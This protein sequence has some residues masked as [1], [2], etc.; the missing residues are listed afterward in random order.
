MAFVV[1]ESCIRCKFMDCVPVCPADCFHAG[2]AMLVIDPQ[3]CIECG[4][5]APECPV[6]AIRPDTDE[7]MGGWALMNSKYAPA[8]PVITAKAVTPTDAMQWVGASGKLQAVF[9]V[10]DP[11]Q[12]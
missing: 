6:H 4:I 8:W 11:A 5:C 2:E 7:G 12:A 9:R 1:T 3:A 10:N